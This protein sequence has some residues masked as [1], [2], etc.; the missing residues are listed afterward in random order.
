MEIIGII[1]ARYGSTRFPGKPLADIK[2]KPV[3]QWVYESSS[4][5]LSHVFV[6]TDDDRIRDAVIDFGGKAVMTS[7]DHTSGTDRCMEAVDRISEEYGLT[8]DVVINVQ[9]DEPFI[10]PEQ[11]AQLAGCFNDPGTQIATLV[12]PVDD[13]EEIFDENKP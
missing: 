2:G 10:K 1:P 6:A 7:P 5:A 13:T 4:Q 12:K 11:I 3:I 9:G 8:A